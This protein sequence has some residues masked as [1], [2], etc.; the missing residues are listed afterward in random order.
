MEAGSATVTGEVRPQIESIC[1]MWQSFFRDCVNKF[2]LPAE[3]VWLVCEDFIYTGANYGGDSAVVST[4]LI[5]GIEGYRMGQA[6]EWNSRRGRRKTVI[7]PMIMQQAGQAKGFAKG[8]R[9]KDWG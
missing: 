5:Y 9:L 7:P 3:N 2:L 6:A 8:Q 1:T 4:A